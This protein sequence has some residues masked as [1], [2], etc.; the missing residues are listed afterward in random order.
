MAQIDRAY[1]ALALAL[2]I[3][4]ELLGFYMGMMNDNKWRAVHIVI[5][6]VG[7]V[8]LAIYGALF[9][10]WPTMTRGV[11]ARAQFWLTVAGLAGTWSAACS[12]RSTAA[13]RCWR[14]A[15]R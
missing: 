10:L 3:I 2:L 5:V 14:R 4:G 8:T 12:R 6:L 15:R 13:S 1:V 7:F 11:L 9:R